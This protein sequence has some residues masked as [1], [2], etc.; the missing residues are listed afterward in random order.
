MR[1]RGIYLGVT[2]ADFLGIISSNDDSTKVKR[3]DGFSLQFI[4]TSLTDQHGTTD[5][6]KKPAN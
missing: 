6:F 5:A 4:L 2:G 1:N 3:K